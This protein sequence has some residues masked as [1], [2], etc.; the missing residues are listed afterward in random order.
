V[1]EMV[2]L[3]RTVKAETVLE[4]VLNDCEGSPPVVFRNPADGLL[5]VYEGLEIVVAAK[6]MG[7]EPV[8][9]IIGD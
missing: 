8:V 5:Y 3:R 4:A 1:D 7:V 2:A 9:V 6:L